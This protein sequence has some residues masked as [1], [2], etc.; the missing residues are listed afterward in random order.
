L[1][2][3]RVKKIKV[4]ESKVSENREASVYDETEDSL[5]LSR[6]EQEWEDIFAESSDNEDN[7]GTP[8]VDWK[9]LL[10]RM[11][12]SAANNGSHLRALYKGESERQKF[13][14]LGKS[15]ELQES[16]KDSRDIRS[17][18][19]PVSKLVP[20]IIG[21]KV[22]DDDDDMSDEGESE[23]AISDRVIEEI[24]ARL[25]VSKNNPDISDE[26]MVK[27]RAVQQYL[28]L[29]KVGNKESQ[30]GLQVAI[31]WGKSVYWGRCVVGWAN[32]WRINKS[33][34]LSR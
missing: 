7:G 18:Y 31:A 3:A 4:A 28:R 27:L 10:A 5:E 9:E 19:P 11:Q 16:T 1:K 2:E 29:R 34:V 14:N 6:L 13:R 25:K 15:K 33:I 26:E 30:A 22:L 17:F 21:T 12:S 24:D 32:Q 20:L 23:E 8:D